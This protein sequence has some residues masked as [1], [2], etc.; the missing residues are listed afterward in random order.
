MARP[1]SGGRARPPRGPTPAPVRPPPKGTGKKHKKER[2]SVV[3]GTM[4]AHAHA[5]DG[6]SCRQ[7]RHLLPR[8]ALLGQ[9]LERTRK[10][11]SAR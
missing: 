5:R 1:H 7:R 2:N 6:Q 3:A 10:E 8:R 11:E 4:A 9:S